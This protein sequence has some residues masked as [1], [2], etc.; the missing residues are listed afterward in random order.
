MH[1]PSITH[2]SAAHTHTLTHLE[3]NL[4]RLDLCVLVAGLARAVLE[5]LHH[6]RT[7]EVIAW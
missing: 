4:H 1:E 6:R 7:L 2:A 5:E 3:C